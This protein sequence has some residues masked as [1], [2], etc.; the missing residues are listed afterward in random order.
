MQ[1]QNYHHSAIFPSITITAAGAAAAAAEA[2][3]GEKEE[4]QRPAAAEKKRPNTKELEYAKMLR[5]NDFR[6]LFRPPSRAT[7]RRRETGEKK[8]FLNI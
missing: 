1:H 3:V 2:V 8:F 4:E 5:E 6:L 7:M